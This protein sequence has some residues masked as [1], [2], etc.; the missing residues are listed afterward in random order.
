MDILALATSGVNAAQSMDTA[1]PVLITAEPAA[2][3]SSASVIT[4]LPR[5]AP[6]LQAQPL[7]SLASS[8]RRLFLRVQHCPIMAPHRPPHKF[9]GPG[10]LPRASLTLLAVP[11]PSSATPLVIHHLEAALPTQLSLT[12]V[13]TTPLATMHRHHPRHRKVLTTLQ[14]LKV[15]ATVDILQQARPPLDTDTVVT[16]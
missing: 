13:E 11:L 8:L 14:A 1:E 15:T 10:L 7:L 3:R 2:I 16:Q 6:L 9:T 5:A 12:M 4:A